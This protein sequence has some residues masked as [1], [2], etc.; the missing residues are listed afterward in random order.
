MALSEL[1]DNDFKEA[2]KSKDS[3]KLSVLRML[4]SAIKNS[5]IENKKPLSDDEI[6]KLLQKEVKQRKDSIDSYTSA[7]RKELADKE[8]SEIKYLEKYLP[9]QLTEQEIEA[10]VSETISE[11]K[12]QTPADIG[13]VM[14]AV[15]PKVAGKADGG[16]ISSK[17]RELLSN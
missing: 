10:I 15:M 17:A 16:V 9:Q 8:I 7:G 11:I 3:E 2:L 13:K 1:I 6:L 14:S 5:E 4:K 12:A